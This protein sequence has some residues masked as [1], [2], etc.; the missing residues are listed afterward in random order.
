[1]KVLVSNYEVKLQWQFALTVYFGFLISDY[2]EQRSINKRVKT[3][4]RETEESFQVPRERTTTAP[5]TCGK[6]C[7]NITEERSTVPRK[8]CDKP[9]GNMALA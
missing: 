7:E 2:S 3:G 4:G 1:M 9:T 5:G 6:E 8:D